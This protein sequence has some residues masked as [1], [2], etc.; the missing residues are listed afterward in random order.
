MNS[1]IMKIS[2]NDFIKWDESITRTFH[3]WEIMIPFGPVGKLQFRQEKFSPEEYET[4]ED[5][6]EAVCDVIRGC[7]F[8]D[9][10]YYVFCDN[11][12]VTDF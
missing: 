12:L 8:T 5:Q 6:Y 4:P 7:R 9:T 10:P 11:R 3:T 1:A 2:K